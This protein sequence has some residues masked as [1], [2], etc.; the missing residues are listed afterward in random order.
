MYQKVT[1]ETRTSAIE[2]EAQ[3]T[4]VAVAVAVVAVAVAVRSVGFLFVFVFAFFFNV[5]VCRA[6]SNI[7]LRFLII[8]T[9]DDCEV[10]HLEGVAL[11]VPTL[12]GTGHAVAHVEVRR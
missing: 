7:G 12:Q 11:L 10:R 9:S 2:Q 5:S 1:N 3:G 8:S 6:E 4:V